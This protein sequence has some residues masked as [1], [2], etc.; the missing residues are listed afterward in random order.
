MG[1]NLIFK[2]TLF[3]SGDAIVVGVLLTAAVILGVALSLSTFTTLPLLISVRKCVLG[4][5]GRP[6]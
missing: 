2:R 5:C 6:I 3:D 1:F 4:R